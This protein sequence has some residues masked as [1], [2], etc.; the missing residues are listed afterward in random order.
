MGASRDPVGARRMLKKQLD[1]LDATGQGRGGE[2]GEGDAL[3]AT[4]QGGS[5]EAA[6]GAD[7]HGEDR[8]Q[9]DADERPGVAAGDAEAPG[10]KATE[11]RGWQQDGTV[12]DIVLSRQG[13]AREPEEPQA[14]DQPYPS[15]NARTQPCR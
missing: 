12:E 15:I 13:N 4:G 9:G 7:R 14:V 2:G 10:V 3:D 11:A 1:A 8:A 6:C 5:G